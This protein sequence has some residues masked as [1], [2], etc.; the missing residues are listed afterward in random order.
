M[1]ITIDDKAKE[2]IAKFANRAKTSNKITITGFCDRNQIRN[3]TDSAMAR[4]VAVRD[5]LL[6]YGVEPANIRMTLNTRVAKKHAAEIKF[7]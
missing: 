6:S 4:A 2:T 1:S 5:A 3:S 7:D